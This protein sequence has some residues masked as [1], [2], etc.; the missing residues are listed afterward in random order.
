M[1][2]LS[3]LKEAYKKVEEDNYIFRRYLKNN[4]DMKTLDQQFLS[5]HKEFFSEYDCNACRNCCVEYSANFEEEELLPVTE[6]L[7]L[8]KKEFID[9]YIEERYG[10]YDLKTKPCAFLKVDGACEIESCKP[11]SCKDYPFTDRPDRMFSLASLVSSTSVC[12]VVY[13]MFERLKEDYN[14]KNRN[15]Y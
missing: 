5:L 9:Q 10:Q 7:N 11:L 8:S 3:E 15:R 13:E 12:P 14:F 6:Y 4:A 1:I 2:K